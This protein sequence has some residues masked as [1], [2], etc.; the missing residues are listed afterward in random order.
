MRAQLQSRRARGNLGS[1]TRSDLAALRE[2]YETML[3]LRLA[4]RGDDPRRAMA[5]LASRFPGALREI[6][7]LPLETIAARITELRACEGGVATTL[8]MEAI[9]L[10]HALTRGALCAKKWLAGRKDIDDAV[11]AAF[12][13]E[14]AELCWEADARAWRDD[15]TRLASP[16]RGR[17]TELVYERMGTLLGVSAAEARLLVFGLSRR[18]RRAEGM[19][20]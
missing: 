10:F 17:V 18:A 6:D 13:R 11:S 14:A 9:H 1:V 8:W 4:P 5:A 19:S 12:D 3:A 15:L 7:E 16:P 2:K 20:S